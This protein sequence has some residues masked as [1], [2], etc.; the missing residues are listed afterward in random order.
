MSTRKIAFCISGQLRTWKK[1]YQTWFDLFQPH[2]HIDVFFHL[3][4]YNTDAAGGGEWTD[5][6]TMLDFPIPEQEKLEL[7]RTLN[8]KSYM[9]EPKR[10]VIN[11]GTVTNIIS[12]Y[13]HSQF[14]GLS[15]VANLK[16]QY[17]IANNF[18]YD[19]V[20]RLRTDLFFAESFQ[21]ISIEPL[22][23]RKWFN[24]IAPSTI[25]STHN[26][27][28]HEHGYMRI[29]DT[30]FLS[31]SLTFDHIALF[32]DSFRYIEAN[33]AVP[34]QKE[35]P[36]EMALYFYLASIGV[37]NVPMPV[38]DFRLM[39]NFRHC[40]RIGELRNYETS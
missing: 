4:D 10:D 22:D 3:W 25:Y 13:A 14:Y 17:E 23:I 34:N 7:I 31:D 20:V 39:R 36:P 9:F 18:D 16:R 35:Y 38:G 33:H 28:V 15:R 40:A 1:C 27:Y 30:F 5:L 32:W 8:P 6:G 21:P 29:G 11:R 12:D 24:E 37:N 2:G 19:V 26:Q